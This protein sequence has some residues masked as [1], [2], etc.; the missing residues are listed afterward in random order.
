MKGTN[1][2]FIATSIDGYIADKDGG[3]D[4]LHMVPN[5]DGKDLGFR[6]FMDRMDALVM[7]RNTFETVLNFDVPWP[8][9]KPVFVLSNRLQEIPESHKDKAYL[10]K[11]ELMDVIKEIHKQ[12]FYHLY[13]DGG[14]TINS[15]LSEDLIDEMVLTTIPVLLGGGAPLFSDFSNSLAFDLV[16]SVVSLDHITQRTYRRKR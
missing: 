7:G 10:V 5:P 12:G 16:S 4:W 15:F 14:T 8:Y 6:S 13:I 2:I 3:L 9:D 11:G 1:N